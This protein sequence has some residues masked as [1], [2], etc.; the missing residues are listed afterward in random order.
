MTNAAIIAFIILIGVFM[1][2]CLWF[3]GNDGGKE[4]GEEDIFND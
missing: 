3:I 2:I 1:F 4:F